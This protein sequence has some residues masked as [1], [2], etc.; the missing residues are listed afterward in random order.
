M[1]VLTDVLRNLQ[2]SGSA[3][4]EL[5]LGAPWSMTIPDV[6]K[7]V[8]YIVLRGECFLR[9]EGETAD[10]GPGDLTFLAHGTAHVLS[11]SPTTDSA[12]I[13]PLLQEGR[14]EEYAHKTGCRL[15]KGGGDGPRTKIIC[16]RFHFK[17][18]GR[19]P[20]LSVLPPLILF[21]SEDIVQAGWLEDSLRF[22]AREARSSE[23]G[24][25]I[26]VDRLLDLIFVQIVRAWLQTEPTLPTGWLGAL[27]HAQVG[28]ALEHLHQEPERD[29]TVN[30]LAREVG[31]S[32]SGFS[33]HFSRLVGEPPLRYLAGWRMRLAAQRL[34]E[35]DLTVG[36]VARS[37]GY[38]SEAAFGAVFK[39]HFGVP[40]GAWRRK[41]KTLVS[42]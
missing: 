40:P 21:R 36:S 32:R 33:A 26:A 9:L 41:E 12:D 30:D 19:H 15:L 1:D 25:Q 5:D 42:Q 22:I 4:G 17:S 29:W 6:D 14:E 35:S 27:S 31:M 11:D 34:V 20:L 8:L 7:A 10:L 23:T 16:A 24:A 37:L 2:V 18:G 13:W 38:C 3:G 39:R 28:E